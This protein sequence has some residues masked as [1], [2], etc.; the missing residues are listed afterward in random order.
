LAPL[1]FI[2]GAP[3]PALLVGSPERGKRQALRRLTAR[4]RHAEQHGSGDG[5]ATTRTSATDTER[6]PPRTDETN[7][8][9]NHE[10][11]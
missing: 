6:L 2:D 7:T 10:D 8:T 1:D 9:I 4:L 3:E 5:D 11:T